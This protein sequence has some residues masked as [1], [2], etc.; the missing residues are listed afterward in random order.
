MRLVV[1]SKWNLDG[2]AYY[3][4]FTITRDYAAAFSDVNMGMRALEGPHSV[5]A[6]TV[7]SWRSQQLLPP[8]K[9]LFLNTTGKSSSTN[10]TTPASCIRYPLLCTWLS[11]ELLAVMYDLFKILLELLVLP[12]QIPSGTNSGIFLVYSG[13][14]FTKYITKNKDLYH[15]FSWNLIIKI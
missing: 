11:F 1:T 10:W 6:N 15:V 13:R 7:M 5:I 3:T 12:I 2:I 8:P 4:A 9:Q 14:Y